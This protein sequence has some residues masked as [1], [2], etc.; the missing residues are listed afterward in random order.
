METAQK[1]QSCGSLSIVRSGPAVPGAE[2]LS[3]AYYVA[4]AVEGVLEG[5]VQATGAAAGAAE[6]RLAA[7]VG[8]VETWLVERSARLLTS[9]YV[10]AGASA[11]ERAGQQPRCTGPAPARHRSALSTAPPSAPLL[12]GCTH[13]AAADPLPAAGL[14]QGCTRALGTAWILLREDEV[15]L[16]MATQSPVRYRLP[17]WPRGASV[18]PAHSEKEF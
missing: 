4:G 3:R 7:A 15:A 14:Y 12:A 18:S 2:L 6:G 5:A 9:A 17:R 11:G 10:A 1:I 8:G 13:T 16:R